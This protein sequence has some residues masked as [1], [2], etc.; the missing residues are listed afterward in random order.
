MTDQVISEI[1]DQRILS[2]AEN[3]E[4]HIE[5]S[6]LNSRKLLE[7]VFEWNRYGWDAEKIKLSMDPSSE[8]I[9]FVSDK[10]ILNRILCNLV[11]NAMEAAQTNETVTAGCRGSGAMVEFWVHNPQYIPESIQTQL[12]HKSFSTKGP[13][14]GLGAYS[15]RLLSRKIG[16]DVSFSSSQKEGTMFV[17]KY[18]KLLSGHGKARER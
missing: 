10:T 17:A 16:G 18:P 1:E 5:P 4:L 9:S 7:Q 14:R 15:I 11:K 6:F 8:E 13:Q 3:H 2:S 12:F